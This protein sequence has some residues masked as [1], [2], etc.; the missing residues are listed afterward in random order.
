[1][2]WLTFPESFDLNFLVCRKSMSDAYRQ[3]VRVSVESAIEQ[4]VDESGIDMNITQ[5]DFFDFN[6][7]ISIDIPSMESS[8][9]TPVMLVPYSTGDYMN[10][11]SAMEAFATPFV[12]SNVSL[13]QKITLALAFSR[14]LEDFPEVESQVNK[15]SA[16]VAAQKEPWT[17]YFHSDVRLFSCNNTEEEDLRRVGLPAALEEARA[18]PGREAHM[19]VAEEANLVASFVNHC[20]RGGGAVSVLRC[21]IPLRRPRFLH[22]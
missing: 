9:T 12:P 1:M 4:I 20:I 8:S 15:V 14:N 10:L 18:E 2:L 13:V 17:Q 19:A 11:P 21:L 7:S 3:N 16:A 5:F 6:E 22:V